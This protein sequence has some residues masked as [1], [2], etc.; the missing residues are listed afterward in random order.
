MRRTFVITVGGTL[1]PIRK[2]IEDID[3]TGETRVVLVYGR[4]FPD[5]RPNQVRAGLGPAGGTGG[6]A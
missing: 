1:G 6:G 5:Q 3:P 4:P 2:S